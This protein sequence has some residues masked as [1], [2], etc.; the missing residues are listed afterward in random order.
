MSRRAWYSTGPMDLRADASIPFARPVV[1]AAYRDE[2]LKL[3]P[4]L[5]DVRR[6]DL[7]SRQDDEGGV[8]RLVN[9]WHGGGELP[10]AARAFLSEAMLSWTDLATWDQN[11]F[12]C[13]WE[14]RTHAFVEAVRC[15]GTSSFREDGAATRLEIRGQIDI[16][17]RK[18]RGVPALFAG[19]V[20]SL[21]EDFLVS[22]IQPNL[23]EVS[24][25]LGQY[26]AARRPA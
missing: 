6:I 7:T 2:L 15:R 19:K 12:T 14:I 24:R 26:L 3:L 21:I 18:L 13:A 9:E 4:Y 16:D 17:A 20:G 25:G 22:K 10:A 23:V 1:F 5:P 8:V 11:A